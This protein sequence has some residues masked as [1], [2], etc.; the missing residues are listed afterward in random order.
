MPST[1]FHLSLS[2]VPQQVSNASGEMECTEVE[3]EGGHLL[4]SILDTDDVFLVDVGSAIYV[5][6]GRGAEPAEKRK[7]MQNA[8]QY[9]KE[10]ERPAW[11]PVTRVVEGGETPVFKSLFYQWDPVQSFD[12]SYRPSATTKVE[13]KAVDVGALHSDSGPAAMVDD[14]SGE[15]RVWICEGTEMS[16][17]PEENYGQFFAGDSYV[18]QYTYHNSSGSTCNILYYWLGRD[19]DIVEKGGAAAHVVELARTIEGP[20]PH[21]RLVQVC[22]AVRG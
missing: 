6:T 2:F 10:H 22:G 16:E 13:A 12:F 20:A 3:Q 8:E 1:L 11:C 21:V 9:I 5:W 15:V 7:G 17:Y 4:R 19:S 14:G 18:I